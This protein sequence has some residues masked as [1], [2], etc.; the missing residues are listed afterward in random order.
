MQEMPFMCHGKNTENETFVFK[1]IIINNS[2]EE[3]ILGVTVDSVTVTD[4]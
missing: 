3:K 1:D 4:F 2:K